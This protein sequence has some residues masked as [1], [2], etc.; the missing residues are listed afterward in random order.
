MTSIIVKLPYSLTGVL[1]ASKNHAF[2]RRAEHSRRARPA[3]TANGAF[4]Q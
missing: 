4:R 2:C 1:L 3:E